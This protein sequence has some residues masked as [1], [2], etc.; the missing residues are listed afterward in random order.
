[1]LLL[2]SLLAFVLTLQLVQLLLLLLLLSL[3]MRWR[4]SSEQ[5]RAGWGRTRFGL[6]RLPEQRMH[7]RLARRRSDR[8]IDPHL[9]PNRVPKVRVSRTRQP[10]LE[11]A[12]A[13]GG[14]HERRWCL[15]HAQLG[16]HID[17]GASRY[18]LLDGGRHAVSRRAEAV[19]AAMDQLHASRPVARAV[20]PHAPDL[21]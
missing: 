16:H 1:L 9:D 2:L 20:V 6:E 7:R 13:V 19:A 15:R 5:R 3:C 14:S 11:V 17:V 21:E 10:Q 4:R 12:L 8:R 18:A